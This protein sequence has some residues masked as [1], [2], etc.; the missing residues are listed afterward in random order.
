MIFNQSRHELQVGTIE[1]IDGRDYVIL[2]VNGTKKFEPT[3]VLTPQGVNANLNTFVVDRAKWG[4]IIVPIDGG[5]NSYSLQSPWAAKATNEVYNAQDNLRMWWPCD[6]AGSGGVGTAISTIQAAVGGLDSGT[7]NNS[8]GN[9]GPVSQESLNPGDNG[10]IQT[11]SALIPGGIS[12]SVTSGREVDFKTATTTGE[13]NSLIGNEVAGNPVSISFWYR[14]ISGPVDPNDRDP[15]I[16]FGEGW[17]T[18]GTYRA[19][20]YARDFAGNYSIIVEWTDNGSPESYVSAVIPELS[21]TRWYH[22]TF[23]RNGSPWVSPG[24]GNWKIYIDGLE[25]STTGI[26]TIAPAGLAKNGSQ[27][28]T[29]YFGGGWWKESMDGYLADVAI[30]DVQLSDENVRA[31]YTASRLGVQEGIEM[32]GQNWFS[33]IKRSTDIGDVTVQYQAIGAS[34]L[35]VK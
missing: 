18:A 2:A 17:G 11:T 34:P 10:H 33:L 25:Q 1:I 14:P 15:I 29:M 19:F 9:I 12:A 13:L 8:G 6:D 5:V 3:I 16:K 32:T 30:W 31:L 35:R 4:S 20:S 27:K 23:T 24:T 21:N 22:I 26:Q 7:I 28:D